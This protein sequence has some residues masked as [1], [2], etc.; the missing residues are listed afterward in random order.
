[1]LSTQLPTHHPKKNPRQV[2]VKRMVALQWWCTSL[3]RCER[4]RL[5]NNDTDTATVEGRNADAQNCD[6]PAHLG[7][8]KS[9]IKV[10]EDQGWLSL[11]HQL[12]YLCLGCWHL[13]SLVNDEWS[14]YWPTVDG[15]NPATT[16]DVW[17]LVNNGI[18]YLSTGAGFQLSTVSL[19]YGRGITWYGW[20]I[21]LV[22]SSIPTAL[23]M[24]SLEE[25]GSCIKMLL[26]AR[27][28]MFMIPWMGKYRLTSWDT[29]NIAM[30]LLDVRISTNTG[31]I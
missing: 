4:Y 5:M 30:H 25:P 11:D 31:F 6:A 14:C 26:R 1:M 3:A 18:N 2:C 8:T 19:Y 17:N 13:T 24:I 20:Y 22:M 16:W 12:P 10:Q 29:E 27:M 7:G 9:S 15:G 21:W 28:V 23:D